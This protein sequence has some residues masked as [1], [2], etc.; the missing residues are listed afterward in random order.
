[1]AGMTAS[2]HTSCTCFLN[3]V[4]G[5]IFLPRD[6]QVSNTKVMGGTRSRERGSWVDVGG[7]NSI[8]WPRSHRSR[9]RSEIGSRST[10]SK[11]AYRR[12]TLPSVPFCAAAHDSHRTMVGSA[13]VY[14]R[15][16]RASVSLSCHG[17][18]CT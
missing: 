7:R 16:P 13:G 6:W 9:P 10:S 2:L 11:P 8:C 1:M 3:T 4:V 18:F 12:T 17:C 14:W 15:G 5:A